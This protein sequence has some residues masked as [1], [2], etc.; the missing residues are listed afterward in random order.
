MNTQQIMIALL[1]AVAIV[2][3]GAT[4][5]YYT[6]EDDETGELFRCGYESSETRI[7]VETQVT[8]DYDGQTVFSWT[9]P[10]PPTLQSDEEQH[11]YTVAIGGMV[12]INTTNDE[13]ST[14]RLIGPNNL[15]DGSFIDINSYQGQNCN[16]RNPSCEKYQT[17]ALGD[18]HITMHFQGEHPEVKKDDI[19]IVFAGTACN[20]QLA[21][22]LEQF[23]DEEPVG[24]GPTEV[25][26]FGILEG[27]AVAVLALCAVLVGR[28]KKAMTSDIVSHSRSKA[29]KRAKKEQET[30]KSR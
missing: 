6:A 10:M 3:A 27:A 23:P 2:H 5:E 17:I 20:D 30:A 8:A 12:E 1:L 4:T 22:S 28:R 25:P 13:G 29:K 9:T 24:E 19:V 11:W 21:E 18:N 26:E 15:P 7:F 14:S 16:V